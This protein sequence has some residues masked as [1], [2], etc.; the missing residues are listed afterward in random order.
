MAFVTSSVMVLAMVSVLWFWQCYRGC[1]ASNSVSNDVSIRASA[2]TSVLR[3]QHCISITALQLWDFNVATTTASPMVYTMK[4][5]LWQSKKDSHHT[6]SLQNPF[7]NRLT[8]YNVLIIVNYVMTI[9]LSYIVCSI[10]FVVIHRWIDIL[11]RSN[12]LESY[13][14]GRLFVER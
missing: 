10:N 3:N 7:S 14:L 5:G 8:R 1:G 4:S 12:I 2:V 11:Q 13:K 6:V 9:L